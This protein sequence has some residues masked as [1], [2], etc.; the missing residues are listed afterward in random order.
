MGA[1]APGDPAMGM[2]GVSVCLSFCNVCV[3]ECAC[4]RV[5]VCMCEVQWKV[6]TF[7]ESRIRNVCFTAGHLMHYKY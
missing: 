3:C 6:D 7:F 4:V 1:A 2:E 5:C